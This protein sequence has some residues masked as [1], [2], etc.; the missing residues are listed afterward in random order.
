MNL[1][2]AARFALLVMM[3][4]PKR[5]PPRRD[6]QASEANAEARAR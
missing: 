5:L 3:G 4:W 2:G 1:A 6:R